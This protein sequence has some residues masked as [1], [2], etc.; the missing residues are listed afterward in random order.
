[1]MIRPAGFGFDPETA[2]SNAFQRE[3][4]EHPCVVQER[5]AAEFDAA[6][7]TLRAKG[8]DIFV[9]EDTVYPVKPDAVFPNNWVSFHRDGTAI[10]YPMF[11]SS[12][13]P[14]RRMEIIDGLRSIFDVGEIVDLSE[15]EQRGRFLEGTGS[16]VLD[17]A[18]AIAY[19]CTSSRT[20]ETLFRE[21][22]ERLGYAPFVFH[23]HDRGGRQIYHTNVMM[24]VAEKFAVV[25]L[26]SITDK[27]E[28]L[29][30]AAS[31]RGTGHELI[32]ITFEQMEEF[33]GN[34]LQLSPND[35]AIVDLSQS[36]FNALSGAQ[37]NIIERHSALVPLDV[38]TIECAGGG[39]VRCMIAEVF[40]PRCL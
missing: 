11:A 36:A 1:M 37:R 16:M 7:E 31:L 24:C 18:N 19:A 23:A 8:V 13:R 32:D 12:R 15:N 40:L 33:A 2:G 10:L 14:E 29:A 22:C 25:C 35:G 17:R 4:D 28:R 34:M 27:K 20:D 9:F 5:A 3:I 39:S 38:P 30:V 6:A 26:D 21:V